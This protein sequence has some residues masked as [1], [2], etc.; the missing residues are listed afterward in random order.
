[1]KIDEIVYERKFDIPQEKRKEIGEYIKNIREEKFITLSEIS[2]KTGI[3]ISDLHKI[4]HG[5]KIK[6]NP[7]Q[8][9]GIGRALN[10]DYKEFYKIVGFL[11]ESDF[12]SKNVLTQPIERINFKEDLISSF[13]QKNTKI[14][15]KN[16]GQFL[17]ILSKLSEDKVI[18]YILYGKFLTEN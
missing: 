12:S 16:L 14:S 15:E 5:N 6:I 13:L 9:K 2:E 4:E 8:L 1:M 11:E 10:I 3:T 18:N 7:F 17:E